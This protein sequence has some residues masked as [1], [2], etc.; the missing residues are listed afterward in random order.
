MHIA[1]AFLLVLYV[2]RFSRI[3]GAIFL[4]YCAM[5]MISSVYLGWH[6]AIDG[7]VAISVTWLIWRLSEPLVKKLH[8]ELTEPA[9]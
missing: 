9:A 1:I 8:P 6:Y 5:M 7:Y 3:L 2:A 4:A